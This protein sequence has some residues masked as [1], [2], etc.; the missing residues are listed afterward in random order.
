MNQL[1]FREGQVA[2]TLQ[3]KG[4]TVVLL[5]GFCEDHH[6]WEDFL[7]QLGDD[8][9]ILAIDLPGF[10]Q[11]SVVADLD[12]DIMAEAVK[13]I[14]DRHGLSRLILIGHSMGGYSALAYAQ[15]Y[16][17]DLAGLGLFHSI[18][19]SDSEERKANRN[20]AIQ[21][22]DRHGHEMYVKQLFP[23]LF[24]PKFV[25]SSAFQLDKL[26]FRAAHFEAAGIQ[27]ALRA[28]CDRPDR[29]AVLQSL[30]VPVLWI[31]GKEDS[32]F[33]EAQMM[34]ASILAEQ[35]SVHYLEGVAHMGMLESPRATARIIRDFVTYCLP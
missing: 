33:S 7:P 20:K 34:K 4:P 6:V 26:T 1:P 22:I 30:H 27:E 15:F 3:G 25:Q 14:V 17:D 13:S 2:Y 5:H 11:S 29:S 12:M 35:N 32:L 10:G 8:L 16:P 19:F 18:P 31:H 9:Q 21:F 28:M 24:T 23:G